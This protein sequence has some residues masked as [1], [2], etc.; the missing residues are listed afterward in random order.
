MSQPLLLR[1]ARQLLTLRGELGAR[2]GTQ[3]GNLQVIED[4]SVFIK[5]G[6]IVSVGAARRLDN[7][8]EVRGA[9]Q[10]PLKNCVVMP[11]FVDP[12]IELGL[13]LR[14]AVTAASGKRRKTKFQDDTLN[15]LR[16]CLQYG[17]LNAG[18]RAAPG[19]DA[20]SSLSVLRH[21]TKFRNS[22]VGITRMWQPHPSLTEFDA[23]VG[24]RILDSI[25]LKTTDSRV[26]LAANARAQ[27]SLELGGTPHDLEQTL[28][29]SD[30]VS[31][32]CDYQ[33]ST[34]EQL[35]LADSKAVTIFKA[36]CNLLEMQP[37]TSLREII[38][39]GCAVALGSGY[40]PVHELNY[41]MQLVLALAVRRLGL[42][43]E[44]ALVATTINAAYA[45][46]CGDLIGSLE[47]D[48][49]ADVLVLYLPDYKEIP[50]QPGVN[51]VAMAIR[52]GEIVINRTKWRLGAA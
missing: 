32:F 42:T 19:S 38:D 30:A 31:V 49:R 4:G 28:A 45:L 39:A 17:T 43:I 13:H 3:S 5:D 50:R 21:L 11:G 51:H 18:I 2:R 27:V 33:L 9:I 6:K 25:C 29:T 12:S 23:V 15:L 8:K 44:E 22:P 20:K 47:P 14:H 36:G 7:L 1:G 10:I 37:E 26:E 52:N 24:K 40:N 16:S 34:E 41:N 48:K 46:G 35:V